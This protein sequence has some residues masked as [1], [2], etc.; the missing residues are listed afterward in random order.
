VVDA[1]DT[2]R[3]FVAALGERD[4]HGRFAEG[5]VDVVDGDRVVGVGGVARDVADDAQT[6]RLGGERLGVDE[7]RDL[8]R[9]VDAVDEDVRLDDFLVWAGLGRGFGEVPLLYGLLVG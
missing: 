1:D 7:G 9:Q 6:A 5:G 4:G 8:G 3:Q 2:E